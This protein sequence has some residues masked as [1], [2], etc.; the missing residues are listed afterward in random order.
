MWFYSLQSEEKS[1]VKSQPLANISSNLQ[2]DL[3]AQL[4]CYDYKPLQEENA[5]RCSVSVLILNNK[6][7]P[8]RPATDCKTA[9]EVVARTSSLYS[10]LVS[11]LLV[12]GGNNIWIDTFTLSGF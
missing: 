2:S 9:A 11:I 1:G 6:V 5:I 7:M 3:Q 10:A 8:Q 4:D 12:L